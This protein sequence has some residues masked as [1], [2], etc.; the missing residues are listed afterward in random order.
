MRF[1]DYRLNGPVVDL[2]GP[3]VFADSGRPIGGSGAAT[4]SLDTPKVAAPLA[5]RRN[6]QHSYCEG[7]VWVGL[8]TLRFRDGERELN[9]RVAEV[10]TTGN[11]QFNLAASS[12][13]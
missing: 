8:W 6:A 11:A 1:S 4:A 7:K 13:F 2:P 5:R 10:A 12:S 9:G 3:F